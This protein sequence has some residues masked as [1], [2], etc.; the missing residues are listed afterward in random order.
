[1]ETERNNEK[2]IIPGLVREEGETREE[3]KER[4]SEGGSQSKP[5]K[6]SLF[7]AGSCRPE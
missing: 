6:Y 2:R 3:N 7:A 5:V 4:G 1:M